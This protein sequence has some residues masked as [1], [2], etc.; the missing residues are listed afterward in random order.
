M[1]KGNILSI[2]QEDPRRGKVSNSNWKN[3]ILH[4]SF[5]DLIVREAVSTSSLDRPFLQVD[6]ALLIP[7]G[8]NDQG[9]NNRNIF[10][11]D[12]YKKFLILNICN[13]L[14]NN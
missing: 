12:N 3:P 11:I 1:I 7:R 14:Y 2:N 13:F 10:F 9:N 4:I 5:T 8:A 6:I